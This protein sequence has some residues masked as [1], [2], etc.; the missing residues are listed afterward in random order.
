MLLETD[1]PVTRKQK[2][3]ADETSWPQTDQVFEPKAV[4]FQAHQWIQQN[5]QIIDNCPNCPRQ[6]IAIPSGTMLVK[7]GGKY[8]IVR[9]SAKGS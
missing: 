4:D 6:A 1:A 3:L 2:E 7:E 9:E 8:T 5:Y